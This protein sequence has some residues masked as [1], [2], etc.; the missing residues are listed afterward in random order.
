MQ[1]ANIKELWRHKKI[2]FDELQKIAETGNADAQFIVG[3]MFLMREGSNQD[4]SKGI[5]LIRKSAY[6][7]NKNAIHFLELFAKEIN[8]ETLQIYNYT[9]RVSKKFTENL[10]SVSV[11]KTKETPTQNQQNESAKKEKLSAYQKYMIGTLA[12]TII[13]II[14]GLLFKSSILGSNIT[15]LTG[16]YG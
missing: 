12:Y 3:T 8:E 7:E 11:D 16:F 2:T 14:I 6:Q 4:L 15:G 13:S 10:N 5:E 9:N 1:S